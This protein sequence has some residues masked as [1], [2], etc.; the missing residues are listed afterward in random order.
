MITRL[1]IADRGEIAIRVA[2][3]AA[4]LGI[5]SV[6]VFATDDDGAPHVVKADAAVALRGTGVP[7][8]LDVDDLLRAA[9]EAGADAVHPGYGFLSESAL[10]ARACAAR[11]ITF[12]GPAPEVL[13]RFGDK[14]SAR[15]LAAG[16]GLPVL[17]GTGPVAVEGADLVRS[18]V[19]F[20][21]IGMELT[22]DVRRWAAW[23]ERSTTSVR[24]S[25]SSGPSGGSACWRRSH[26]TG[27]R[28][29]SRW[30]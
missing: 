20:M 22:H 7:A 26:R 17:A 23:W 21:A 9:E 3:A 29:S 15:D 11:G 14:T 30:G 4:E 25:R 13:A 19:S 24:S 2:R 28:T 16:L 8:Y 6:A 12:V 27:H 18:C 5:G 10:F 1:L